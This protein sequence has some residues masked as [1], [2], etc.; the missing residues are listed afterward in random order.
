MPQKGVTIIAVKDG[1][2]TLG[3]AEVVPDVGPGSVTSAG[4]SLS[5]PG[6]DVHRTDPSRHR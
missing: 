6:P 4:P 3:A 2:F 5:G 1:A